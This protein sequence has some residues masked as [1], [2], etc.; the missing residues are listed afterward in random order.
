MNTFLRGLLVFF[1]F[2]LYR[3]LARGC[4]SPGQ[5]LCEVKPVSPSPPPLEPERHMQIP[6]VSSNCSSLINANPTFA[7]GRLLWL[8]FPSFVADCALNNLIYSSIHR[9]SF[10]CGAC[11]YHLFCKRGVFLSHRHRAT[12]AGPKRCFRALLLTDGSSFPWVLPCA[13]RGAVEDQPRVCKQDVVVMYQR[14]CSCAKRVFL[15]GHFHLPRAPSSLLSAASSKE[16]GR[17]RILFNRELV[18]IQAPWSE[19]RTWVSCRLA[20]G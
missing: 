13:S 2:F 4:L 15:T 7:G 5:V 6:A 11:F 14:L 19:R 8:V 3:A 1:L 10:L 18:F 12:S 9:L 16:G 20:G 17:R